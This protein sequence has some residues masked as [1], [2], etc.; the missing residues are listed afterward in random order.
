MRILT[1]L[2]LKSKIYSNEISSPGRHQCLQYLKTLRN[3]QNDGLYTVYLGET[4][5][6][7]NLI[8]GDVSDSIAKAKSSLDG[9]TLIHAGGVRGWVPWQ[10]RAFFQSQELW[11]CPK[12]TGGSDQTFEELCQVLRKSYGKCTVVIRSKYCVPAPGLQLQNSSDDPSASPPWKPEVIQ[13][14]PSQ[15]PLAIQ[16]TK[17]SCPKIAKHYGHELLYLPPSYPHLSPLESA[18]SS[19]KWSIINNRKDFTVTALPKINDYKCI[20]LK[21][22]IENAIEGVTPCKWKVSFNRVKKWENQYLYN[23]A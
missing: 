13:N 18:W 8:T 2:L 19:L 5:I 16:I 9:L 1:K 4:L 12:A 23:Q 20:H 7:E 15:S 10:Y 22:L 11:T 14:T 6:S 17:I 21:S 3:F